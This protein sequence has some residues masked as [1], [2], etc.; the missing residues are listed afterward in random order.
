[1][2]IAIFILVAMFIS[3][4]SKKPSDIIHSSKQEQAGWV[5]EKPG[6]DPVMKYEEYYQ[7]SP[8]W[9]QSISYASKSSS[10]AVTVVLGLLCFIGAIT[11]FVLKAKDSNLISEKTDKFILHIA[12]GLL[13]IGIYVLYSKPGEIR[14]NNDK[15]VKKEV[16][17]KAVKEAGSTQ[18][19]WDSLE[20]N[21]LIVGKN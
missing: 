11:L 4:C 13:V 1:M 10:F 19:I 18:P 9:G 14:F 5:V 16:Y 6:Q 17:D 12:F 21:N 8:T 3:A 2:V 7:I 15:W 20:V